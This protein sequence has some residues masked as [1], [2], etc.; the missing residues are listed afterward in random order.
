RTLWSCSSLSNFVSIQ[1]TTPIC[2]HFLR[3]RATMKFVDRKPQQQT[4]SIRIS[5]SLREFLERSKK[6]IA[7]GRNGV[8]STS[9]VAKI[10]LES[11]KDDGL[12]YRLEVA[13]LGQKPTEAMV[14]IRKKWEL[15]QPR[16]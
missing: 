16:S 1:I 4:L 14:G 11:A 12:D 8:V 7:T 15:G 13:E 3:R 9:D 6:V 2:L 5:E 10:L